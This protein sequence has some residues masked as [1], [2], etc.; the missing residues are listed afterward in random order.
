MLAFDLSKTESFDSLD[1]W[2]SEVE[3]YG[4]HHIVKMLVGM[5]NLSPDEF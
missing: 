3:K 2:Y 1:R 4:T 5:Y